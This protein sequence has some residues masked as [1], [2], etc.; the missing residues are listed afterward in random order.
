MMER[1]RYFRIS[2]P[3]FERVKTTMVTSSHTC[4]ATICTCFACK[5]VTFVPRVFGDSKCCI[6]VSL[7]RFTACPFS[8]MGDYARIEL[9]DE[10]SPLNT[11]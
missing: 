7:L 3:Y 6:A 8:G 2:V 10:T 5:V 9:R 1:G 4:V 11:S